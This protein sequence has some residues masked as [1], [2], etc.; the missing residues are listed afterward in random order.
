M[1]TKRAELG[2]LKFAEDA[3]AAFKKDPNMATYG[4]VTAGSFLALRWGMGNDCVLV[5]KLDE[6]D[7]PVNFQQL[8]REV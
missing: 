3:A 1:T 8:V 5:V 2:R 4:D 7:E 6:N